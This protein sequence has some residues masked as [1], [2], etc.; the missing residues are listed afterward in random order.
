MDAT[1]AD[2]S[3][4]APAICLCSHRFTERGVRVWERKEEFDGGQ[5][6]GESGR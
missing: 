6:Q 3:A 1:G 4:L 5:G 2:N